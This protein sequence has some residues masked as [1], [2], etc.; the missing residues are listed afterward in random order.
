[1]GELKERWKRCQALAHRFE[2]DDEN[3][4]VLLDRMIDNKQLSNRRQMLLTNKV[5]FLYRSVLK[6]LEVYIR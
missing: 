6:N 5:S 3:E 2:L 4:D 1:M